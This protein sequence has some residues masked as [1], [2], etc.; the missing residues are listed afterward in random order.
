MIPA[1]KDLAA[2]VFGMIHHV[3]A[4]D[5][6][7]AQRIENGDVGCRLRVVERVVVFGIEKARIADGDHR[8]LALPLDLGRTKIDCAALYELCTPFNRFRFRKQH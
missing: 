3:A 7:L 4:Q 8:G 5:T 2:A 6:N 1:R